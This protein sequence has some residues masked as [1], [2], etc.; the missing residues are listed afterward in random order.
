MG[1]LIEWQTLRGNKLKSAGVTDRELASLYDL[2]MQARN[3]GCETTQDDF[4]RRIAYSTVLIG[5]D[6]EQMTT[7][8]VYDYQPYSKHSYVE[9]DTLA[10]HERYRGQG[11][12]SFALHQ[13]IQEARS[14]ECDYVRL[15]A[16]SSAVSFYQAHGFGFEYSIETNSRYVPMRLNLAYASL[17]EETTLRTPVKSV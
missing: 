15:S 10:V 8:G 3:K 2:Y 14:L 5:A 9:L 7:L 17:P 16:R 1:E 6:M 13:V 4:E 11:F 12:G